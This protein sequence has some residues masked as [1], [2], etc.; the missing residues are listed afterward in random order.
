M[1][2]QV[3]GGLRVDGE[4]VSGL[5]GA[6]I[7]LLVVTREYPALDLPS[8]SGP[9]AAPASGQLTRMRMLRGHGHEIVPIETSANGAAA[10][11]GC[12]TK[13][14]S[15][16]TGSANSPS[17][18]P[19]AELPAVH[20]STRAVW[21]PAAALSLRPGV[22]AAREELAHA[23]DGVCDGDRRVRRGARD[24]VPVEGDDGAR[25][26]Q[27]EPGGALASVNTERTSVNHN[28]VMPVGYPP[29]KRVC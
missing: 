4:P 6:L 9:T 18:D 3:H 24:A 17:R 23:R 25:V 28:R 7:A 29:P 20:R 11:S 16:P 22:L 5:R 2:V 15:M 26:A 13:S 10:F 1:R 8:C 12:P 14:R 27:G 19:R 21:S